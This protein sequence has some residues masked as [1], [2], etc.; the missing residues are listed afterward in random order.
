MSRIMIVDDDVDLA[1]LIRTKLTA[2][3]HE[4]SVIH[5]GDGAFEM[6]KQVKPD[7]IILDI[8]LP[9]ETGYRIC[10]RLRR[11][12]EL[13]QMGILILTALGEEP[14]V[15][16]GLEQG[17]DDYLSKPFKLDHLMDKIAS[18]EAL[19]ESAKHRHSTTGL[20]GTEAI[21]R[22]IN[23]RLARGMAIACC[24]IDMVGFKPYCAVMGADAQNRALSFV[25]N[26]LTVLTRQMGV[27]ESFIAHL[28]G[29][30]FVVM[31]NLEDY[32][33]FCNSL[34]EMFDQKVK[35]LYT[36]EQVQQGY[37]VATDRRGKTGKYPLMK[38]SIGVAHNQFRQHKSAKKMFEVLAQTRQMAKPVNKSA[39]FVDRR[40][41]DR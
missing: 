7:L 35:E 12:P 27:Y 34:I 8:M 40:Q 21:K 26:L 18:L 41:A 39:V 30:H 1:Q 25:A 23:H 5:S 32:E 15:L 6:A 28:G 14:E 3:G 13:Y 4:V 24:Y 10:R 19:L 9:G 29:E 2:E 33:R 22:E 20:P 11:D 17:A 31:V 37:I 16:H 38:L 36:P